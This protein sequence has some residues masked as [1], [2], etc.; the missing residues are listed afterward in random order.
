MEKRETTHKE[1]RER[2][3]SCMGAELGNYYHHLENEL[4]FLYMK[5]QEY[6]GLFGKEECVNV[7]NETASG[8]FFIIQQS[9]WDDIVLHVARLGWTGLSRPRNVIS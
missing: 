6:L 3:V 2:Y 5:W 4:T 1:E 9:L 7:L 8:S